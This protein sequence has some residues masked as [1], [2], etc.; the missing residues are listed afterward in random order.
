MEREECIGLPI[1]TVTR[2]HT[3]V[4]G[5]AFV[6]LTTAQN[7]RAL[8]MRACCRHRTVLGGRNH[9]LN[10]AVGNHENDTVSRRGEARCYSLFATSPARSVRCRLTATSEILYLYRI[11]CLN[12]LGFFRHC[13]EDPLCT[14]TNNRPL[15]TLRTAFGRA[16]VRPTRAARH[17]D[18]IALVASVATHA[19]PPRSSGR[20]HAKII[21][22]LRPMARASFFVTR[23]Q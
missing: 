8:A 9:R 19:S 11:M 17:H 4:R 13:C 14:Y 20:F 16:R 5:E 21:G 12:F 18:A 15:C 3:R 7:R 2:V 22:Q 23:P 10:D 1:A 6:C